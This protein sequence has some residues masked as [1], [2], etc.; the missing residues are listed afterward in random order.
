MSA[1]K[2]SVISVFSGLQLPTWLVGALRFVLAAG[3]LAL[4]WRQVAEQSITQAAFAGLV[5]AP[6]QYGLLSAVG[7]LML[8]N[9]GLEALKW[10]TMVGVFQEMSFYESA[11][12][13]LSGVALAIVTPARIGEYGGRLFNIEKQHRSKA[14]LGNAVSS[15]A[16]NIANVSIGLVGLVCYA[17]LFLD[18]GSVALVSMLSLIVPLV[19]LALLVIYR[20]DLVE[21]ALE[22]LPITGMRSWLQEHSA[23]LSAYT[24]RDISYVL[25]LSFVRYCTYAVQYVLLALVCGITTDPVWA[26][27]GVTVIFLIQTGI[28]LPPMLSILA[29][30]EVAIWV[31]S[32]MSTAV[33]PIL[34]ATFLLWLINLVIPAVC[35]VAVI[36]LS[37]Q[38]A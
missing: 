5:H 23:V 35:G 27:V 3:L 18:M 37:K 15:L 33:V 31:W 22:R 36:W 6:W 24:A 38:R 20:L 12:A 2:E 25:S 13:V 21:P 28:P 4:I 29:R 10:Q 1:N 34:A 7:L 30:G 14:L 17:L 32:V 11:R 16:Q 19:G 26:L 9:W 8:L